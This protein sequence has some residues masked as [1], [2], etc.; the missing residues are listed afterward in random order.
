MYKTTRGYVGQVGNPR[1]LRDFLFELD[2]GCD[3]GVQL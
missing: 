2:H 1:K 3:F